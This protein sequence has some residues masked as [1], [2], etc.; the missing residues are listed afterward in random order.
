MS[1]LQ[2][3]EGIWETR[4]GRQVTL[5]KNHNSLAERGWKW[6]GFVGLV[7]TYWNEQGKC[8]ASWPDGCDL[9]RCV[10]GSRQGD[11]ERDS[12]RAQ[13]AD[14]NR[15]AD[16][17]QKEADFVRRDSAAKEREL[18]GQIRKLTALVQTLQAQLADATA[19]V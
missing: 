6:S 4:D 16:E 12:L 19:Q 2:V 5:S 11:A 1:E 14:A 15:L 3:G 13:L 10:L 17:I 18:I 7:H 8:L 9:G